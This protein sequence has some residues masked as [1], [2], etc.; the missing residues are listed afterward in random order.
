MKQ[1][2]L[3][4]SLLFFLSV[5]AQ[6][7]DL[8]TLVNQL[9]TE[10]QSEND[11]AKKLFLLDSLTSVVRDKPNFPYDSIARTTIDLAIKLDSFNLAAY[12][13]TNLINYH[14]NFLGKPKTGITIFNTYFKTLKNNINAR[15]LASLY[16]DSGDSYYFTQQV[17]SAMAHYDKAI[18]Y[19][20]KAKDN[21]VKGFAV[22][23]KGYAYS[24]EGKFVLAS[25]TLKQASEV[26]IQ[27]KDTFNIIAAKNALSLLY[28]ANGF[29]E[30]AQQERT[31]TI[32]LAEIT[33]SYG[34]LIPLYVNEATDNKK[35]NL[36]TQRIKNLHK[37]LEANKK[38]NYVDYFKPILLNELVVA[39][40][41]NDSL[42]KAN[43]HLKE[44]EKD[45]RNTEGIYTPNYYNALKKLAYANKQ[46]QKAEALGIKHLT[47]LKET[48]DINDIQKA[49]AFLS[50]VYEAINKP[51]QAL[52]H[53]KAS[54]HIIDSI[55]SVQKTKALAYYQTLYETEKRDQKMIRRVPPPHHPG[56]CRDCRATVHTT[57][58]L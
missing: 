54:Q 46:Y 37:A 29:L 36:Q 26:F 48:N 10:I 58:C 41:E 45:T 28:S 57:L 39:Y 9:K 3:V 14:N 52:A 1:F 2:S 43:F 19:A 7:S 4:F 18:T 38:S 32:A 51:S 15:N 6:N 23:Y 22:L 24:D 21:R 8:H 56:H 12:N 31:E 35:Q 44:I 55:K 5:N 47:I 20:E 16:I 25:Q 49:E 27:E 53:F 13:T 17:D 50:Q 34:Q 42:D 33:K 30:E 40:A 11:N